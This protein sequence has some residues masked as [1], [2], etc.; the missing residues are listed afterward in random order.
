LV[1]PDAAV[2]WSALAKAAFPAAAWHRAARPADALPGEVSARLELPGLPVSMARSLLPEVSAAWCA[3]VGSRS[4][5]PAVAYAPAVPQSAELPWAASDAAVVPR[6]EA[7]VSDA[8]AEPR[9]EAA[10]AALGA[11]AGR[12]QGAAVAALGAAA[13]LRQEAAVAASDVAAAPQQVV[14][15]PDA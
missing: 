14:A 9:Q 15:E 7:A 3:Q 8:A 11:A 12:R 6:R 4:E 2:A 5:V 1:L 10:V 13:G